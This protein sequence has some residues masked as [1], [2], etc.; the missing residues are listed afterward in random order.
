MCNNKNV[1]KRKK[2]EMNKN[3]KKCLELCEENE[4]KTKE[5][6]ES[7]KRLNKAINDLGNPKFKKVKM[8]G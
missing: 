3:L 4:R 5:M 6:L 2:Q 8:W 7:F 1:S